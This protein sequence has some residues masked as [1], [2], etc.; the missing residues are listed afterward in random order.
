M[1]N[2]STAALLVVAAA[3]SF[4][5]VFFWSW[6]YE[7][8]LRANKEP[9]QIKIL[10]RRDITDQTTIYLVEVEGETILIL[11][12]VNKCAVSKL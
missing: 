1:R 11:N 12:G 3:S 7:T 8:S 6:N 9:S 4:V 2:F 5:T 10:D